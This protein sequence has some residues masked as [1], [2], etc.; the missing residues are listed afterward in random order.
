MNKKLPDNLDDIK[1]E[2]RISRREK[3]QLL[4]GIVLVIIIL[5]GAGI[6]IFWQRQ[7]SSNADTATIKK[8]DLEALQSEIADLKRRT[9]DLSSHLTAA[10]EEGGLKITQETIKT[11]TSTSA[12]GK[13]AGASI[14]GVININT[15]S[16]AE[17]D[18]LPGI[19]PAYAGRIIDYRQAY[20]GF[21][22]IEEIVNVKG[23]GPKTFDKIKD[24]IT[25]E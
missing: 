21:K 14:E 20:G 17:L 10:Q 19:G 12:S 3:I 16:A 9:A 22:S 6:L 11:Q 15:A 18:K 4:V 24:Y 5:T 2:K 1:P 7:A 8:G 23:I 25:V 13:V